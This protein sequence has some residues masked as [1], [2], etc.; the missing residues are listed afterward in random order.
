MFVIVL[1][2]LYS[3]S[4]SCVQGKGVT[5]SLLQKQGKNCVQE[6]EKIIKDSNTKVEVCDVMA[7]NTVETKV[8]HVNEDRLNLDRF[9]ECLKRYEAIDVAQ[10]VHNSQIII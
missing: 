2:V 1:K 8:V 9:K 7:E 5:R 6:V 4:L 10:K 3:E